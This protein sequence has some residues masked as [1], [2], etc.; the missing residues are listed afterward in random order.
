[1]KSNPTGRLFGGQCLAHYT[2]VDYA[3]QSYL[4]AVGL[5]ILF[6]H[7]ATVPT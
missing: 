5:L 4:A 3:T 2:F 7:N 6:F 1:V